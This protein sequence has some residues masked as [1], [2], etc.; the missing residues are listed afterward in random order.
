MHRQQHHIVRA[1]AAITWASEFVIVGGQAVLGQFS[2]IPRNCWISIEAIFA[3]A[4]WLTFSVSVNVRD[5]LSVLQFNRV[6]HDVL[7]TRGKLSP[8][9]GAIEVDVS[10]IDGS[11]TNAN[12]VAVVIYSLTRFFG[13]IQNNRN[14]FGARLDFILLHCSKIINYL[15]H[16]RPFKNPFRKGFAIPRRTVGG[17]RFGIAAGFFAR[18]FRLCRRETSFRTN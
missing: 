3:A 7:V 8:K 11:D 12:F 2:Q 10:V 14:E 5:S 17:V 18:E 16:G 13:L 1:A 9:I 6:A 15:R 4:R